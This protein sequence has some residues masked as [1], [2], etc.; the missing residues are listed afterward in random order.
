MLLDLLG[1]L[2]SVGLVLDLPALQ[3]F[4]ILV[5]VGH[6]LLLWEI[7]EGLRDEPGDFEHGLVLVGLLDFLSSLV[8]IPEKGIQG[9]LGRRRWGFHH[10]L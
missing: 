5:L 9:L 10:C 6:P 1:V 4:L 7:F 2:L 8:E 3:L